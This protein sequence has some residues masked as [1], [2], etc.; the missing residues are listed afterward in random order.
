MGLAQARPNDHVGLAQARP[1]YLSL[2]RHPILLLCL[3]NSH[4]IIM[5]NVP[6]IYTHYTDTSTTPDHPP[7]DN[8]PSSSEGYDSVNTAASDSDGPVSNSSNTLDNK[9]DSVTCAGK[10]T[11]N[12]TL[13][14]VINFKV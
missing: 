10:S 5:Y 3:T 13:T 7:E 4:F 9:D 8:S 11:C 6:C 14:H 12:N 2:T 1:K